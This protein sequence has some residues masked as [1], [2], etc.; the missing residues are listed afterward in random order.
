MVSIVVVVE[1][2]Q[3]ELFHNASFALMQLGSTLFGHVVLAPTHLAVVHH[4]PT[5]LLQ[6]ER[7]AKELLK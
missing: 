7:I 5:C 4:F 2:I 3:N 1:D 6:V